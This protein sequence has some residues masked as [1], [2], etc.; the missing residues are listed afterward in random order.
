MERFPNYFST[1]TGAPLVPPLRVCRQ[2]WWNIMAKEIPL[3]RG[4]VAIVDD[5]WYEMLS[6]V[7][8]NADKHGYAK[9]GWRVKGKHYGCKM[10]RLIIDAPKGYHVDHIN[11]NTSDNRRANLRLCDSARNQH[12][13]AKSIGLTSVYSGVHWNS[14]NKKWIAQM[15][16]GGKRKYLGS[17]D[18][19]ID[20]AKAY[21]DAGIYYRGEFFATI[22]S[23]QALQQKGGGDESR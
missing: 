11:G 5:D 8:W 7:R 23:K 12:N 19:E 6:L 15:N 14:A 4:K 20:A 17:Y 21:N 16:V 22:L 13:S 9:S 1:M 10:H 3:T 2:L 18:S